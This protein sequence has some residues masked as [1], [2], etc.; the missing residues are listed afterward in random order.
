MSLTNSLGPLCRRAPVGVVL[1]EAFP[2][3]KGGDHHLVDGQFV[4]GAVLSVGR[5]G[6][7]RQQQQ[8]ADSAH[9]DWSPAG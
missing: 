1:G 5:D 8:R 9:V 4:D 7:G 6:H 2:G 3:P